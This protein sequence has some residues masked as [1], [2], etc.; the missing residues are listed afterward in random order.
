MNLNQACNNILNQLYLL[1]DQISDEDFVKPIGALSNS[2]IGQHVR[3]TVEFFLCLKKGFEQGIINYD[4]RSHDKLIET[5][6]QAAVNA[7]QQ[8][9]GF[10][11][12]QS[13]DKPLLLEV[14]YDLSTDKFVS[15]QSNYWREL[16]YNI[17]HAVH[18]MAIIKIG[19][20]DAAPYVQLP[21][22]FGVAASTI[23]Y[24]EMTAHA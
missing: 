17:E 21:F 16:V 9:T 8:I 10:I 7:I 18:H 2:T 15:I 4:K 1:I 11:S 24:Q 5:N 19:V 20:R 3:H 22:D 13:G 12:T 14:G 23:R 6:K